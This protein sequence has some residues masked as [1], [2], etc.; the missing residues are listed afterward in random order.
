MSVSQVIIQ[1][2]N[3]SASIFTLR[4]LETWLF[5]KTFKNV[6][7]SL[8]CRCKRKI[9]I[10]FN[11]WKDAR[12]FWHDALQNYTIAAPS[13]DFTCILCYALTLHLVARTNICALIYTPVKKYEVEFFW[14]WDQQSMK[15]LCPLH[16]LKLQ[17]NWWISIVVNK[18]YLPVPFKCFPHLKIPTLLLPVYYKTIKESHMR[19]SVPRFPSF[20]LVQ[21]SRNLQFTNYYYLIFFGQSRSHVSIY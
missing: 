13:L 21:V 15:K 16:N 7:F 4:Y 10:S 6:H 17:E 18:I 14:N 11:R 20:C 19:M 5:L 9:V 1:I 3:V 2:I 12:I 8:L